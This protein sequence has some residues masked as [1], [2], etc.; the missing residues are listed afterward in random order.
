M[1]MQ[2]VAAYRIHTHAFRFPGAER[3]GRKLNVPSSERHET[4]LAERQESLSINPFCVRRIA[5]S[6]FSV[7]MWTAATAAAICIVAHTFNDF[8]TSSMNA[9]PIARRRPRS[10]VGPMFAACKRFA[11][12]FST[13][14]R[15]SIS[16]SVRCFKRIHSLSLSFLLSPYLAVCR[17][18]P[19]DRFA[20]G[21]LTA[22]DQLGV[23]RW[24]NR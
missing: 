2:F 13:R 20:L 19:V 10:G 11:E 9:L 22:R 15:H 1:C 16:A 23:K 24:R 3:L 5:F 21:R 17:L 6:F 4:E 14:V 18:V 7:P 8:D 12:G